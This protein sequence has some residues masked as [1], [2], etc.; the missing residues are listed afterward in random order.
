MPMKHVKILSGSELILPEHTE[1]EAAKKQRNAAFR[2]LD[3]A[4][5]RRAGLVTGGTDTQILAAL[6]MAR[7]EC[8]EIE[9]RLRFQSRDWLKARGL[10]RLHGLAFEEGDK[11]PTGLV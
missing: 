1:L 8:D 3:V 7:Y 10:G 6:H 4:W 5:A 11:L 9:D 2:A